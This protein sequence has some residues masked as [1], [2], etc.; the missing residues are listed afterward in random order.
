MF[1]GRATLQS[2][3]L[4]LY[5]TKRFIPTSN[6][7]NVNNNNKKFTNHNN[8]NNRKNKSNTNNNNNNSKKRNKNKSKKL[9]NKNAQKLYLFTTKVPKLYNN[10]NKIKPK[11][12]VKEQSISSKKVTTTERS[13]YF[14]SVSNTNLKFDHDSVVKQYLKFV[15]NITITYP[16]MIPA[17]DLMKTYNF[18]KK[19]QKLK[20]KSR[21]INSNRNIKVFIPT[22]IV[23]TI[24]PTQKT[25][26]ITKE[27]AT[28]GN[29]KA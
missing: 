25:T 20:E 11:I 15:K 13:P 14:Y 8:G 6:N 3:T 2:W 10:N 4:V 19:A 18:N 7:N 28:T 22:P 17:R 27:I 29:Y 12:N 1:L 24:L 23:E 21:D 16:I 9:K 26:A 5:G